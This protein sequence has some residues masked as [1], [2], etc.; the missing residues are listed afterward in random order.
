MCSNVQRLYMS[1]K[2][3]GIVYKKNYLL[4]S[5]LR[6]DIELMR[7]Q[8]QRSASIKKKNKSW[9]DTNEGLGFLYKPGTENNKMDAKFL[10]RK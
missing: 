3:G 2:L 4:N 7:S 6:L 9:Y 8:M 1:K 5:D 10:R